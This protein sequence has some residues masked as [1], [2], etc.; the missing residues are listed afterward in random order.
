[1]GVRSSLFER[2]KKMSLGKLSCKCKRFLNL[3]FILKLDWCHLT[4][5][6]SVQYEFRS[7]F[8]RINV[9]VDRRGWNE[10]SGRQSKPLWLF[11]SLLVRRQENHWICK[12][13]KAYSYQN[14]IVVFWSLFLNSWLISIGMLIDCLF[15]Y[16]G[17]QGKL[18]LF[19][20]KTSCEG[21]WD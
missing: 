21:M 10:S 19:R 5:T 16:K 14:R 20:W 3:N 11:Q 17:W 6:Y 4:F 9:W 18:K 8:E 15:V 12:F 7:K 2:R 1:M 13:S